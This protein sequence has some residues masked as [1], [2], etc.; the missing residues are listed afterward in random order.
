MFQYLLLRQEQ[1]TLISSWTISSHSI[2]V[3]GAF[4]LTTQNFLQLKCDKISKS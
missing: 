4:D 2:N 3:E 1:L